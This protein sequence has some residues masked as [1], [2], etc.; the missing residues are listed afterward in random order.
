MQMLEVLWLVAR[1]KH[2]LRSTPRCLLGDGRRDLCVHV[3]DNQCR[4]V[5]DILLDSLALCRTA[6][7]QGEKSSNNCL[8]AGRPALVSVGDD[9]TERG[10]ELIPIGGNRVCK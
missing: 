9:E 1:E 8:L 6:R 5:I 4:C 2:V 7:K 10:K 3:A